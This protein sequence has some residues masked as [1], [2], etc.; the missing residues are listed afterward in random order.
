MKI[1]VWILLVVI[2]ATSFRS[3]A[4]VN[5]E[6]R[7][8]TEHIDYRI[9]EVYGAYLSE[10]IKKPIVLQTITDIVQK[11]T[12]ILIEPYFPQEKI[13]KLSDYPLFNVYNTELTRDIEINPYT[14]NVLKYDLP[15][16]PKSPT[17][18]R[19]DG[20]DYIIVIYPFEQVKP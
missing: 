6:E 2:L 3:F 15:F 20:T 11:R 8:S 19:I 13:A 9:K 18:Y 10:L 5:S 17:K 12:E 1:K 14:F 16:F 7:S 4:Q